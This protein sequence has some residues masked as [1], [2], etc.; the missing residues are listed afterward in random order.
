M[1]P[2]WG[3]LQSTQSVLSNRYAGSVFVRMRASGHMFVQH[4]MSAIFLSHET[5]NG[6][7]GCLLDDVVHVDEG[8]VDRREAV[9]V[10]DHVLGRN[11]SGLRFGTGERIADGGETGPEVLT[12]DRTES[13]RL[14]VEEA[15]GKTVRELSRLWQY[16]GGK[17][18]D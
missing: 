2:R 16:Q 8:T 11:D 10:E 17:C 3:V 6:Q 5:T 15:R 1:V 14:I 7:S 9:A 18:P 12:F 4:Y 13:G